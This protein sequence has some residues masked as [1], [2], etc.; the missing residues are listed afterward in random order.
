M[1][2]GRCKPPLLQVP[3]SG[4]VRSRRG[5]HAVGTPPAPSPPSVGTEGRGEAGSFH[6]RSPEEMAIAAG[7]GQPRGAAVRLPQRSG[8]VPCAALRCAAQGR[9]FPPRVPPLL[10]CEPGGS[11]LGLLFFFFF[12]LTSLQHPLVP[13]AIKSVLKRGSRRSSCSRVPRKDASLGRR[14]PAGTSQMAPAAMRRC[15]VP[16]RC[17]ARGG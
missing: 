14:G 7:A 6:L 1:F 12:H 17:A 3:P 8:G 10:G 5:P 2:P 11:R 13:A 4:V 9:G 16:R 15:P